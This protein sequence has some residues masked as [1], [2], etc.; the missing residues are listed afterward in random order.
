MWQLYAALASK[1]AAESGVKKA[2]AEQL[3]TL[4]A[5]EGN[6]VLVQTAETSIAIEVEEETVENFTISYVSGLSESTEWV[7]RTYVN[8]E[9]GIQEAVEEFLSHYPD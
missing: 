3:A 8:N 1:I 4:D 2:L 6:S 5:I 9:A 7:T